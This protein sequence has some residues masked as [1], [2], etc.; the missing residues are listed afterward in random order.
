MSDDDSIDALDAL[1]LVDPLA[2]DGDGP[3]AKGSTRYRSILERAMNATDTDDVTPTTTAPAAAAGRPTPDPAHG[4]ADG[5]ALAPR[6]RHG[7][8]RRITALSVAAAALAIAGVVTVLRP[9]G[10]VS[11][12]AAITR[13]AEA[14][15]DVTSLRGTLT[16]VDPAHEGTT[17]VEVAGDDMRFETRGTYADGH[18]EG[19]TTVIIDDEVTEVDLDGEVEY[20]TIDEPGERPAPFGASSTAVVTAALDHGEPV[21]LG[22]EEVRGAEATH[23]RIEPDDAVRRSLAEVAPTELGWFGLEYVDHVTA[24]DIWVAD[25]LIR[26][27]EVVQDLP[28]DI[29]NVPGEHATTI[30]FYDFNADIEIEPLAVDPS[31]PVVG[32]G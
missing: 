3:P 15:A 9:D 17:T 12:A 1:R 30:D 20:S 6:G 27:I 28:A 31:A 11:A 26:R 7:R 5:N 22:T 14:T 8:R 23:Y 25:D 10:G 13:A 16:E 21:D 18:V 32:E 2:G 29:T 24:I 4:P 19:S